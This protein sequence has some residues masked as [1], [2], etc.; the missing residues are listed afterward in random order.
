MKNESDW[1]HLFRLG[2]EAAF[3]LLFERYSPLLFNYGYKFTQEESII[4]DSI[5]EF[6]MKIWYNRDSINDTPSVKNY[7]YKAFRRTLTA[8]IEQSNRKRNIPVES[9]PFDIE[10][11]HDTQVMRKERLEEIKAQL[12]EALLKMTARQREVIHLRFFEELSYEEIADIMGLSVK[13]LYKLFY[14]AMDSL[15]KHVGAFNLLA[16]FTL[17]AEAKSS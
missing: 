13:D 9:L 12:E 5:Q 1:W 10:L 15:R 8:H 4:E 17:L 3:K 2:D 11:P 14:R 7:L 16:I 6:F